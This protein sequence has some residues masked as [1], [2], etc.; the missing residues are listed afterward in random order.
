MAAPVHGSTQLRGIEPLERRLADRTE[1]VVV[2]LHRDGCRFCDE[3]A[4]VYESLARMVHVSN[5][6][7]TDR[8][9]TSFYRLNGGRHRAQLAAA[10]PALV[11]SF[12][13]VLY[14]RAAEGAARLWPSETPRTKWNLLREFA[15][16]FRDPTLRPYPAL[17][18]RQL[19]APAPAKAR[20]TLFY[21][22]AEHA[23][24]DPVCERFAAAECPPGGCPPQVA[25]D[26]SLALA[27]HGARFAQ[28][29]G[30]AAVDV[31]APAAATQ[32]GRPLQRVPAPTLL[33]GDSKAMY[34]GNEIV[35]LLRD[36]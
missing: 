27:R 19:Q 17:G 15:A 28:K 7:G 16:Y 20:W 31:D 25:H 35:A 8:P 9:K 29:G 12:P 6:E 24:V 23:A 13:T 1:N 2:L 21:S 10:R 5:P 3:F 32:G 30:F 33:D 22:G 14:Q 11:Q 18:F 4:P 36:A 26:V 34:H